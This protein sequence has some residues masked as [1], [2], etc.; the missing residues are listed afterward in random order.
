MSF[1]VVATV[2]GVC[3]VR[4]GVVL[5]AGLPGGELAGGAHGR[6][7][8]HCQMWRAGLMP[9]NTCACG[10]VEPHEADAV[11]IPEARAGVGEE[12]RMEQCVARRG[13]GCVR[14]HAS[15]VE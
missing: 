1:L 8:G 9:H 4:R 11:R 7:R 12:P 15:G 2:A 13:I 14:I 6:V 5:Q 3:A 10:V